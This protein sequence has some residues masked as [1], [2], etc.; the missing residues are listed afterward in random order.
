MY[1]KRLWT[2]DVNITKR[3][4]A[5]EIRCYS[6]TERLYI[7]YPCGYYWPGYGIEYRRLAA[8][9]VR[10]GW[11][12]ETLKCG[13]FPIVRRVFLCATAT[14]G[15]EGIGRWLAVHGVHSLGHLT[16]AVVPECR[17]DTVYVGHSEGLGEIVQQ[18]KFYLEGFK[19]AVAP[20]A[21]PKN[22]YFQQ[23]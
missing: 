4:Q 23:S 12:T 11:R 14:S 8:R 6:I 22:P 2:R 5:G 17:I 18:Q 15:S 9:S 21:K 1:L 3:L 20:W 19:G 7:T 16:D 13:I 10:I